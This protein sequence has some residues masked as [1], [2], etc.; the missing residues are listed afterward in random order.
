MSQMNK[1]ED[2]LKPWCMQGNHSSKINSLQWLWCWQCLS[3]KDYPDHQ[4]EAGYDQ[5]RAS[6]TPEEI[7]LW[8]LYC[9]NMKLL[10]CISIKNRLR[11]FVHTNGKYLC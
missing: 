1:Q 7:R 8:C 11:I 9:E 2:V 3:A 4:G 10:A 6:E 5:P